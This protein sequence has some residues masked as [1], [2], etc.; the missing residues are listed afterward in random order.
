[1]D[2]A[3]ADQDA[4]ALALEIRRAL[5]RRGKSEAPGRLDEDLH[6]AGQEAHAV[7][8]FRVGCRED[9][10]HVLLDDRERDVAEVLC[11]RP[12]CDGLGRV[13]VHD[14]AAAQRALAVVAGLRLDAE[15]LATWR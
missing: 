14:G 7:H 5:T 1:M 2:I 6:V 13:D 11:L 4:D 15:E 10:V 12:F 3:A 9:V 8:Q